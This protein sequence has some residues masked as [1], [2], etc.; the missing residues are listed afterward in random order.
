MST[1]HTPDA[2]TF[3]STLSTVIQSGIQVLIWAGDAGKTPIF[4][5]HTR[6]PMHGS[7]SLR[8]SPDWICNT[9][10]VQAVIA[11]LQFAQSAGFNSKSLV[12]YTVSGV[13]YGVFKTAGNLSFLNVFNAGH[14]VPAYQ[15]VL[16]LQAFIQTL[17]QQPLSSS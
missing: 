3:L 16:S 14:E 15:P 11:Q 17:T 13:Q 8:L 7:R 1:Y 5:L 12:P 2:R 4:R 10:G 6:S 9:A